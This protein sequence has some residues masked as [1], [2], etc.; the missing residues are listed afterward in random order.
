MR[1]KGRMSDGVS[2]TVQPTILTRE[3]FRD[4]VDDHGRDL[5]RLAF[6]LTGNE[7]DAE[8]VVQE[9]FMRAYRWRSRFDG[10]CRVTTWLY[11]IAS[12]AS[13]DLLRRRK[14]RSGET[15]LDSASP[16]PA[17]AVQEH[18]VAGGEV[19]SRIQEA[20]ELLS[21]T[22]RTAFVLRHCQGCSIREIAQALDSSETAAKH[23]VFR[24]VRK[25]REQLEPLRG[26]R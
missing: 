9:T 20:M 3:S 23:A 22:E 15:E 2:L 24:A 14:R 4:V 11:R 25:L 21:P 6:R 17:S 8:E 13:M 18:L 12:N 26:E 10:R 1:L 19:G 16:P 7:A 5:F